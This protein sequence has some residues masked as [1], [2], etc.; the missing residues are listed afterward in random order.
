MRHVF[1]D[2]GGTLEAGGEP[3]PGVVPALTAIAGLPDQ[4]GRR[5][6]LGLISDFEMPGAPSEIPA[7][8]A[9]Y[10]Q[11]LRDLGI[12]QF[13]QPFARAVTLS[14]QVGV[15]KPDPRIFHAALAKRDATARFEDAIFVTEHVPH[16]VAARALG[17]HALHLQGPD[18]SSGEI[19]SF[20][21]LIDAITRLVR[22]PG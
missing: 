2:L 18:Q 20:P 12:D 17:I 22:P 14:T 3:R 15:L 6:T 21:A 5:V 4:N 10:R 8:E 9:K 11:V 7:I 19:P 13:F 1:F 16:V